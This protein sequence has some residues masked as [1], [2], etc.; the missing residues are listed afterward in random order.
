[1]PSK[2][3]KN[4]NVRAHIETAELFQD[5]FEQSGANSK[6][7]FISMLLENYLNPDYESKVKAVKDQVDKKGKENESL[8]L[9]LNEAN[10]TATMLE[11]EIAFFDEKLDPILQNHLGE[12]VAI[13]DPETK[14]KV[15]IEI[16]SIQDVFEVIMKSVKIK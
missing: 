3:Q 7:E 8:L 13:K 2:N 4:I 12:L 15:E 6:G 10:T 11:N 9:K 14:E 5:T 16:N 1:M